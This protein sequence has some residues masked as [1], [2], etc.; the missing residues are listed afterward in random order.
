V[1]TWVDGEGLTVATKEEKGKLSVTI[2]TDAVPGTRW[3]RVFDD[4]GASAPIP[5]IV[6]NLPETLETEPNEGATD[7]L[8]PMVA[9]VVANG[10]LGRSGDVDVWL[11]N[12]RR[13]QTLV[14]SLMAHEGL[15]SPV[16]AVM[17]IVSSRGQMLALNHD[18][19]GLDPEITFVAPSDDNYLVRVFGFPSTPN[20]TIGFAGGDSY[21]YRLTLATSPFVD[22]CWPLA[23]TRG[24]E[25]RVELFGWNIADPERIITPV[26]ERD[27]F[28]IADPRLANTASV[29]VE[30][31][32]TIVE[33]EP[34]D[35]AAAQAITL[36]VTITGRIDP[37]GDI[38]AFAFIGKK[39]NPLTFDLASRELGY[40]LDAVVEV[41][42]AEGKSLIRVDDLGEARDPSL[43]FTP[44]ADGPFRLVV[45]DLNNSGS[46]R[47]VYRLR[48]S[49]AEPT[50]QVVASGQAFELSAEKPADV[51]LSIDRQQG[52]AEEISFRV[53]GLPEFV[54]V[55]DAVSAASGD[56]AKSVKLTLTSKGGKFSGPIRI[57]GE[58][59]GPLKLSR[60][61]TA[62][63][64]NHTVRSENLWLTAVDAKTQ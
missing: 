61:A 45:Q 53:E 6:G 1:Q 8:A 25:S 15:G 24:R 13:G 47:H 21:V 14:A 41:L 18:Q 42:D 63:I 52:F 51:G 9:P 35:L 3:I 56:S 40:P 2:A 5:F 59:S 37:P 34:N 60:R 29:R 12:L 26:A 23:V 32:E 49:K 43:T 31:H 46:V 16:D 64:P 22:Y 30:E 58:S 7:A 27:E 28:P 36:P 11:V 57:I 20:T 10:R 50:F 4:A 19:R 17:Q 39:G 55:A 44:P 33:I 62:A 54:S 38:D 48:A